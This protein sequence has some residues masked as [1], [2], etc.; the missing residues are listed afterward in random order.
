MGD[1]HDFFVAEAGAAGV[2]TGLVC[3][4]VS[5]NLERILSEPGSGLTGRSAAEALILLM[6]VLTV[7]SLLL[8]PGQGRG[9]VGTEVL[10]VGIAAWAWVL[11]IQAL[12]QSASDAISAAKTNAVD[13]LLFLTVAAPLPAKGARIC[14]PTAV[15]KRQEHI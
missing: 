2:L 7:S 15:A 3:V 14:C 5:M 12:R 6:A 8:V 9:L 1:W 4:G 13:L 10:V 11:A